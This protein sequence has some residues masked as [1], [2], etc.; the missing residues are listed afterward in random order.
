MRYRE[1]IIC[2]ELGS[3]SQHRAPFPN[4]GGQGEAKRGS[5]PGHAPNRSESR[6][7]LGILRPLVM[8]RKPLPRLL[9]NLLQRS[10]STFSRGS[11][12][13]FFAFKEGML[14]TP[15]FGTG[16]LANSIPPFFVTAS[17][18]HTTC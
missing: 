14:S 6:R 8:S 17:C 16:A 5:V 9:P 10:R 7:T 12:L 15:I 4:P 1:L 18:S 3:E 2:R 11:F 13:S